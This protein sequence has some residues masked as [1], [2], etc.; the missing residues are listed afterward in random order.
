MLNLTEDARR[1]VARFISTSKTPVTGLRIAVTGGGCSG[2]QYAMKLEGAAA[3]ED[4][5]VECG[6]ARVF[7][8]PQSAPLLVGVTV[9]FQDSLEGSG[10]VFENPNAKSGCGCGKSFTA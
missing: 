3:A 10:F 9:D 7:V 4:T 8:D 1:A 5:V 6:D 2:F